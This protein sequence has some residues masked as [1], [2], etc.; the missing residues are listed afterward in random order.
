MTLRSVL[1]GKHSSSI[2]KLSLETSDAEGYASQWGLKDE[3]PPASRG[4]KFGKH[5][6]AAAEDFKIVFC[7]EN[8]RGGI[9]RESY[10]ERL[11]RE[12][13]FSIC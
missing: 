2:L 1:Y 12:F 4:R 13:H 6:S 10:A 3:A 11:P 9:T 5:R 7:P 8:S